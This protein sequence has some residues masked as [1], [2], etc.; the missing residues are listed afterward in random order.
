LLNFDV[1]VYKDVFQRICYISVVVIWVGIYFKLN[2]ID[3]DSFSLNLWVCDSE[4]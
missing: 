4:L 3:L 1:F 2:A